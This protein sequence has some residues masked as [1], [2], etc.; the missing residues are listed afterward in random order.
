MSCCT[1][2]TDNSYFVRII[3]G[4]LCAYLWLTYQFALSYLVLSAHSCADLIHLSSVQCVLRPLGLLATVDR[5]ASSTVLYGT[6][7]SQSVILS[8]RRYEVIFRTRQH[9]AQQASSDPPPSRPFL[10]RRTPQPRL[11]IPIPLG[12]STAQ[13]NKP[14]RIRNRQSVLQGFVFALGRVERAGTTLM[15]RHS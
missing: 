14:N 8:V 12:G 13:T 7:T 5:L 4:L 15:C 6:V 1:P 10:P 9:A 2:T 11:P 3:W